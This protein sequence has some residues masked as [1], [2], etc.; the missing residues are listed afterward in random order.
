MNTA[1]VLDDYLEQLLGDAVPTAPAPA[2][3]P[4]AP[5]A[6]VVAQDGA[7]AAGVALA[8]SAEFVRSTAPAADAMRDAAVD[9]T[10]GAPAESLATAHQTPTSPGSPANLALLDELMNDPALGPPVDNRATAHETPTSPGSPANLALL[11]ELMNDPALGPPV[12]SRPIAH[13]TPT[14]PG[15]PANLALLDELPRPAARPTSRCSTNS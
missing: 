3:V 9:T 15:S 13:Q 12:D 11:D 8:I 7:E 10:L 14:S 6:A 2:D 1:G 5:A 4:A